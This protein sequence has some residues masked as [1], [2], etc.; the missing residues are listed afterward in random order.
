M[1]LLKFVPFASRGIE[2]GVIEFLFCVPL[3]KLVL[4]L[5]ADPVS[6]FRAP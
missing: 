2:I 3:Q 5:F 4:I 6:S 1:A